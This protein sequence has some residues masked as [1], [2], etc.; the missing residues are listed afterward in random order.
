[1]KQ[2]SGS[3][4]AGGVAIRAELELLASEIVDVPTGAKELKDAVFYPL[5]ALL[6]V[7]MIGAAMIEGW[8]QPKC[9]PFGGADGPADYSLIILN[10]GDLCRM[11]AYL[12]Y[13]LELKDEV[14]TIKAD[15]TANVASVQHNAHFRLGPDLENVYAG[16]TLRIS[17]TVKPSDGFGAEAFEFNYSTGKPGDT[18]WTRFDLKP[19]WDTYTAEV[20][21]PRKLLES[22]TAFDYI[23][24]RPVV[25]DKTRSI[26]LREI[27][28]RRLGE[29]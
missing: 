6:A 3:R 9:G 13:D 25:P 28:F 17:L 4:F 19:G 11:E 14:L 5:V 10:G 27:R 23:S 1:L 20:N 15:E 12:G 8:S 7:L 18:G 21:I 2:R 29:W 26:D 16:R 22:S 24:V